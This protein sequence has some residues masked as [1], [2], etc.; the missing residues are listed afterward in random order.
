MVGGDAGRSKILVKGKNNAKKG[1]RGLPAG[2]SAALAGSTSTTLQ[3]HSSDGA[4]TCYGSTFG[5]VLKNAANLFK[6]K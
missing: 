5:T 3:L 4:T 1:Q 2:I 6:A